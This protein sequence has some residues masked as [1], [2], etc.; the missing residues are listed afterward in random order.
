MCVSVAHHMLRQ[1]SETTQRDDWEGDFNWSFEHQGEDAREADHEQH[2][3][4]ETDLAKH[5]DQV[6]PNTAQR[7]LHGFKPK[8]AIEKIWKEEGL[9]NN[10]HHDQAPR[11]FAQ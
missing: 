9:S 11:A 10:T 8:V 3:P 4:G 6:L 5:R 1:S 2:R 7:T